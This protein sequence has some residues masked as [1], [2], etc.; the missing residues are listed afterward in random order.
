[1]NRL[2][3]KSWLELVGVTVGMALTGVCVAVLVHLDSKGMDT[4]LIGGAV[5]LIAGL[6]V[7][8]RCASAEAKLDE[9]E[10]AILRKAFEWAS[11]T[12]ILFWGGSS[13]VAFFAVGGKGTIEVYWLPLLFAAGLFLAQFV[14]SAVVLIQSAKEAHEQ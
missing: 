9:R 5:G 10:K 2:E 12:V 1:M 7:Y 11:K 14:Q 3:R 4:L 8:V 6:V 13:F